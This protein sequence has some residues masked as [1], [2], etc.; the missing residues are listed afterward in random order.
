MQKLMN[1]IPVFIEQ[2]EGNFSIHVMYEKGIKMYHLRRF[3]GRGKIS[4]LV[5]SMLMAI[6]HNIGKLHHKIQSGRSGQYLFP[7]NNAA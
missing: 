4:A 3:L 6:A 1:K 5:E 2:V 7:V